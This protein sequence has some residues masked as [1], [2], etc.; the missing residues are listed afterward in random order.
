MFARGAHHGRRREGGSCGSAA[1]WPLAA[2][3]EPQ[4]RHVTTPAHAGCCFGVGPALSHTLCVAC[5]ACSRVFCAA[6]LAV[7]GTRYRRRTSSHLIEGRRHRTSVA[8]RT[9]CGS[10]GE[11]RDRPDVSTFSAVIG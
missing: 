8:P 4:R 1:G 7:L 3:A 9:Q 11:S 5:S 10:R 2:V 6:H